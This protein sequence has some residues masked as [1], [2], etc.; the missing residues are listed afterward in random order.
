MNTNIILNSTSEYLF[1]SLNKKGQ[2]I[3]TLS[4]NKDKKYS[5]PDGEAYIRVSNLNKI[6]GRT[7]IIH[8]GAPNSSKG[9][10]E[11][12]MLLSILKTK[13]IKPLEIFFTYFPYGQ[14]DKIFLPGEL[15]M[16]K[17]ILDK[18]VNCY[19]VS[20]IYLIDPHFS[21]REWLKKY[22]IKIISAFK[23][24][25]DIILKQYPDIFFISADYGQSKRSGITG[26]KK[27]RL[28]SFRVKFILSNKLKKKIKGHD[29]CI[30]D[31]LVETG[32]TLSKLALECHKV[33]A[34]KII[35]FVSHSVLTRG[36]KKAKEASNKFYTTNSIKRRKFLININD[37][38]IKNIN[39]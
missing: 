23:L 12:E 1:N 18:L 29:V 16:A 10:V 19:K 5:F 20:K 36:V 11:L 27:K 24:F 35:I 4:K 13:K 9:L 15:N 32:G 39:I 38:I 14:Q 6:Q 8:S 30:I 22:P 26:A 28:D 17:D 21:Y 3:F 34:K 33:G 7:I 31:D 37:L 25:R 2:S